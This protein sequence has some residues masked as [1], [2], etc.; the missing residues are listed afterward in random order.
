[1]AEIS[2][3]MAQVEIER[4]YRVVGLLEKLAK[5][6]EHEVL[7]TISREKA[8]IKRKVLWGDGIIF[9]LLGA[10]LVTLTVMAG[11]WD[12]FT[13]APAWWDGILAD[14][15]LSGLMLTLLVGVFGYVHYRVRK[16]VVNSTL[17]SLDAHATTEFGEWIANAMRVNTNSWRTV[18]I[19][20]P[21]GWGPL[22]RRRIA[23]VLSDADR[24]VQAL[25]DRVT[26]SSGHQTP[27][28][29]IR[30]FESEIDPMGRLS[31][32]DEPAEKHQGSPSVIGE[33]ST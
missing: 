3:R 30:S 2:D 7:P 22:T 16:F 21:A 20:S 5:R 11:Y 24:F 1:M 31:P 6:I 28:P 19:T 27:N 32:Q 18:L 33:A 9:G 10:A 25:N 13:F 12:G 8:S 26:S 23:S 15:I 29:A 17:R 14:P 4:S